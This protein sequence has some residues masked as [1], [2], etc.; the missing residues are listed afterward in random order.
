MK[1]K[2]RTRAG[3]GGNLKTSCR[4]MCND[5]YRTYYNKKYCIGKNKRESEEKAERDIKEEE[6]KASGAKSLGT[7][8]Y[9]SISDM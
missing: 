9:Q 5:L 4:T 2:I 7:Q 3:I 8:F 6:K 1:K